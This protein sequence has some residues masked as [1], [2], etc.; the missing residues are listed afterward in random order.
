MSGI[1]I[2]CVFLTNYLE[3]IAGAGIINDWLYL[4]Q[5]TERN[6][7]GIVVKI[8]YFDTNWKLK[9]IEQGER[10]FL[11]INDSEKQ[12]DFWTWGPSLQAN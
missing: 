11:K 9:R 8:C 4:L 7:A 12:N 10:Q 1:C 5:I 6:C 2:S 3:Q